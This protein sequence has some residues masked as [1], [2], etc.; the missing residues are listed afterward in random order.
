MR[1]LLP[2][3]IHSKIKGAPPSMAALTAPQVHASLRVRDLSTVVDNNL[4]SRI[5]SSLYIT[6]LSSPVSHSHL[7]SHHQCYHSSVSCTFS[8]CIFAVLHWSS[9]AESWRWNGFPL[10]QISAS[11]LNCSLCIHPSKLGYNKLKCMQ[12]Q[13]YIYISHW[14]E[15]GGIFQHLNKKLIIW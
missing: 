3:S 2:L 9:N 11:S 1:Y 5:D 8:H 14:D 4:T 6:S 15:T 10:S 12:R 13:Q 7:H